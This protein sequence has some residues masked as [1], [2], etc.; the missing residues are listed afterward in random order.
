MSHCGL[1]YMVRVE[2]SRCGSFTIVRSIGAKDRDVIARLS[3]WLR[4]RSSRGAE[5]PVLTTTVL[6]ETI[7][8][9][10]RYSPDEKQQKLLAAIRSLTD[11]PGREVSLIPERDLPLAWAQDVR[12][13]EFYADSLLE[14]RLI[15]Y[16][17]TLT[18][19]DPRYTVVITA[20]GWAYF[21]EKNS[22]ISHRTPANEAPC[23]P[24]VESRA[25]LLLI[26]V[27]ENETKALLEV[28]EENAGHPAKPNTIGDRVYRDLGNVDGLRVFHAL[29]EMGS[30][31]VG[32]AQ[33]TAEKAIQSV[34]PKAVIGVGIAFGSNEA[35]QSIGEILVSKQLL[36][37]ELQRVGSEIRPRGDRA[38]SSPK[39][40]NFFTGFA[41]TSW[42]GEQVT[43]GLL[44]S[45]EKLVDNVDYRSQL[46]NLESEAV[47]GEMEG[48]GLYASC[49]DNKVDW[50]IIKSI[51]DWGDGKKFKNKKERQLKAARSAANFLLQ[52]LRHTPLYLGPVPE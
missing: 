8:T 18:H 46:L 17:D 4:E 42:K 52:A 38:H 32:A 28:F 48:A 44:L 10:P 34:R 15:K 6:D 24:G 31:G 2:C 5:I 11:V 29:S 35:E 7:S 30:V 37:Y 12:E 9:L 40:I 16:S 19:S 49:Q 51:C 26:T 20:A 1:A 22:E 43:P 14:K 13:F 41:Q 36:L 33:Q 45:G 39:L 21:E 23:V 27:N 25:D 3:A 47:G 50:I